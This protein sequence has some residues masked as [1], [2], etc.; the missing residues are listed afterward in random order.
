[1]RFA[2]LH[3]R[4]ILIAA[5]LCALPA[6]SLA[7]ENPKAAAKAAPAPSMT[8][9]M[10]SDFPGLPADLPRYVEPES[11]SVDLVVKADGQDMVMKRFIDKSRI[12]TE[13]EAMGQQIVMIEVGDEKGTTYTLMP[14][15]K[16]AIKQTRA[17]MMAFAK[18]NM[19]E[20][21][22][23]T[24]Q[25]SAG[26]PPDMKIEDLGDET[27]DGRAV[28]KV[29]F[30]MTQGAALA[31][32]DKSDGAPVRMESNAEGQKAAMEWKNLKPGPQ[33]AALFEIPKKYEVTDMDEMMV[34]MKKMQAQGGMNPLA[35]MAGMGGMPGMGG[36]LSGMAGS[37]GQNF[38]S[39]LGSSFGGALG[40]A[41]GGPL[42]SIAGQFIGGK[43][44]GMI[45]KKAAEMVTPGK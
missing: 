19:P 14:S 35:G 6:T 23:E 33:P 21:A 11:Y 44:G 39:N 28:K 9:G 22:S 15:D 3:A 29:R 26:P 43:V 16:R 34:Q 24:A 37:M 30:V 42:G 13:L 5:L 1:M 20:A 12:R 8:R 2:L 17:A 40:G 4:Q 41:L 31:W 36:G 38:G 25:D 7:K 32:F 18:Q 10:T 45:G 27:L